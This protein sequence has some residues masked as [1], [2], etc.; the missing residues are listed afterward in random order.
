[1]PPSLSFNSSWIRLERLQDCLPV[2]LT[3]L[4]GDFLRH[5]HPDADVLAHPDEEFEERD[6]PLPDRDD[7]QECLFLRK[8][9]RENGMTKPMIWSAESI[10]SIGLV[11]CSEPENRLLVSW[12]V[13]FISAM[14]RP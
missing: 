5:L 13:S 14:I 10:W 11:N 7:F 1:M 3:H 2:R 6:V 4:V 12:M 9:E 8:G